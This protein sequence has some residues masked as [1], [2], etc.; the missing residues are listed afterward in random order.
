MMGSATTNGR[1]GGLAV[2]L[3]GAQFWLV[4]GLVLE[5]ELGG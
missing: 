5:P 1:V 3:L 2:W 4:P